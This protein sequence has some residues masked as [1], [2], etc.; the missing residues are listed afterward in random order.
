[1]VAD[2]FARENPERMIKDAIYKHDYFYGEAF[3]SRIVGEA[4]K[5]LAERLEITIKK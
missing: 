4:A 5:I 2:A 1:M 3:N